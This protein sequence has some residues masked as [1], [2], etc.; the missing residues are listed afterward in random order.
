M[1]SG[2]FLRIR[3]FE[4]DFWWKENLEWGGK[5][6]GLLSGKAEQEVVVVRR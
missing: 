5:R 6:Q 1:Y 3:A 4:I 2:W